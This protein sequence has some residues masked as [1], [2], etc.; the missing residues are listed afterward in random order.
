[1]KNISRKI[2][3]CIL[4]LI[5]VPSHEVRPVSDAIK[6]TG[7]GILSSAVIA[8]FVWMNW[9][10]IQNKREVTRLRTDNGE[11][12]DVLVYHRDV[13]ENFYDRIKGPVA[14][15][16]AVELEQ[17]R[18]DLSTE[19]RKQ[20]Q[21]HGERLTALQ[22]NV[23]EGSKFAFEIEERVHSLEQL[24]RRMWSSDSHR[25][26]ADICSFERAIK[27]LELLPSESNEST[28]DDKETVD[29]SRR[30]TKLRASHKFL[31]D[32]YWMFPRMPIIRL[33]HRMVI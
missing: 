19:I 21:P 20:L 7:Y 24:E 33:P 18:A 30:L 8:W 27:D 17:Q 22:V 25:V 11:I 10:M 2:L 12:R 26:L 23:D 6:F 3:L 4:V 29:V 31:S 28:S 16:I 32:L 15:A 5:C 13:V 9:V 14:T 1:M